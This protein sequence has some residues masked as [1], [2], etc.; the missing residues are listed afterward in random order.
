L[1]TLHFR[2]VGGDMVEMYKILAGKYDVAVT[3]KVNRVYD[4][5]TRGNTFKLNKD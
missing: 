1:S 3:S 2:Q 5:T 4:S